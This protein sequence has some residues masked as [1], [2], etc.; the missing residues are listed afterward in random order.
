MP[1]A[2][3]RTEYGKQPSVG[4]LLIHSAIGI[5]KLAFRIILIYSDDWR[6]SAG[7]TII[8]SQKGQA[9]NRPSGLAP[10]MKRSN[11]LRTG[12]DRVSAFPAG[13]VSG[14]G[15][16]RCGN[17]GVEAG[18]ASVI[19]I[20]I[21]FSDPVADG[22][23]IQ[24]A[25][26]AALA[27]KVKVADVFRT[28]TSVRPKLTIPV[29]GML[30]YSIVFRYGVD[31]FVR[32]AKSAGFDGLILPDLP[33]PEAK[34]I[35][36]KVRAAELDTILLVAPTTTE[37]RR[38]QIGEL[39]SG[40]VYYLSVAGITGERRPASARFGC[41]SPRPQT[42][43][44]P[45]SLRRFWHPQ[46]A[47]H[48]PARRNRRRRDRRDGLCSAHE[49]PPHRRVRPYQSNLGSLYPGAAERGPVLSPQNPVL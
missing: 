42:V 36:G 19:E 18:G 27:R 48:C 10:Y 31:K 15:N 32:D 21:P 6:R 43:E 45:P 12:S 39:S 22:P 5:R 17:A 4:C 24:E 35:C 44:R 46:T 7:P 41:K 29:V 1:N 9:C 3:C 37:E 34:S 38:K 16:N 33:P 8:A 2:K 28:L 25:F 30:S 13:R 11:R 14:F 20:G 47:A 49:G 26:T 40:F 23:I